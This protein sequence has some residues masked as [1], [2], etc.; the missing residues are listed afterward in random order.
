MG[1]L[2]ERK[3][4]GRRPSR[5]RAAH[6]PLSLRPARPSAPPRPSARAQP[7]PAQAAS[8]GPAPGRP[9]LQRAAHFPNPSAPAVAQQRAGAFFPSRCLHARPCRRRSR[10]PACTPAAARARLHARSPCCTSRAHDPLA[11]AAPRAEHLRPAAPFPN[12]RRA[13]AVVARAQP[14]PAQSVHGGGKSTPRSCPCPASSSS[15]CPRRLDPD[16]QRVHIPLRKNT[17]HNPVS[18]SVVPAA[19]GR[20]RSCHG[21]QLAQH[22]CSLLF[23]T[24]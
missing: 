10:S 16:T 24:A 9:T 8:R 17:R 12:R 5:S 19:P 20:A 11:L 18:R 2:K 14:A 13:C 7:T 1:K 6:N 3:T 4:K 21:N 15:T 22:P 23:Q